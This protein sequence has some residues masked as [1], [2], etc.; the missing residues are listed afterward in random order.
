MALKVRE[1]GEE[2]VKNPAS[3]KYPP[4]RGGHLLAVLLGVKRGSGAFDF[5]VNARVNTRD[6]SW[7]ADEYHGE[8]VKFLLGGLAWQAGVHPVRI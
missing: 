4:L 3:F 7:R 6:A 2:A 5:C 1:G 8:P